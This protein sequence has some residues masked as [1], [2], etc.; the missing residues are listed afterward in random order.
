[1][2]T[3]AVVR[4]AT[5]TTDPGPSLARLAR[6]PEQVTFTLCLEFVLPRKPWTYD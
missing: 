3:G 1:M 5:R 4:L 2:R 6:S